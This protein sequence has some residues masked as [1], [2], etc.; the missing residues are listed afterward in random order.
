MD[1]AERRVWRG[2]SA[3]E[4]VAISLRAIV[5][6][7]PEEPLAWTTMPTAQGA[8]YDKLR[9][10][11]YAA[12]ERLRPAAVWL[13]TLTELAQTQLELLWVQHV[14]SEEHEHE[15]SG[16]AHRPSSEFRLL[17]WRFRRSFSHAWVALLA[18][19]A[20]P[21][22]LLAH[23]DD[24][25]LIDAV[26]GHRLEL[27]RARLTATHSVARELLGTIEYPEVDRQ[28]DDAV[29]TL[30]GLRKSGGS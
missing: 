21:P 15:A 22:I 18:L 27:C 13:E 19:E 17:E 12:V 28:A 10:I 3:R 1:P 20:A 23:F 8:E 25:D 6:G 26:L 30:L 7:R 9:T 4:R 24:Q 11:G 5:A 16:L 14:S 29:R 2:L